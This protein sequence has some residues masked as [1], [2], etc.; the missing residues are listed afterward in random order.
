[1]NVFDF[2][3]EFRLSLSKARAIKKRYPQMF[4]EDESAV[5]TLRAYLSKGVGITT[6]QLVDL[7][8]NPSWLLSLGQYAG[9]AEEA[10]AALKKPQSQ[11][12]P[13]EVVANIME[14]AKGEREAVQILV[15]WLRTIIPTTPVNHAFIAT[16]L[17]LGIPESIRKFEAPRIP[18]ALLNVRQHPDFSNY[19]HIE[20][21]VSRNKTVYQKKV[22]DL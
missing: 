2:S 12:A 10:L 15:D 9:K 5:D 19:W 18:R 22:F 16:R 11:V 1:M 17:L 21:G 6:M 13:K 8:E 3:E 7:I 14:A 20:K 4:D